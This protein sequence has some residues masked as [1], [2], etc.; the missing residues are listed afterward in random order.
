MRLHLPLCSVLRLY[1]MWGSDCLT[2]RSRILARQCDSWKQQQIF[3]CSLAA[4]PGETCQL[5]HAPR[6]ADSEE[7]RDEERKRLQVIS[8][9]KGQRTVGKWRQTE[10]QSCPYDIESLGVFIAWKSTVAT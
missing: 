5:R 4:N 2:L 7:E 9:K 8:K 3:P 10:I 6:G 1:V